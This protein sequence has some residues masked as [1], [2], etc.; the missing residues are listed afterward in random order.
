MRNQVNRWITAIKENR[1]FEN[2]APLIGTIF[3]SD[4]EQ[5]RSRRLIPREAASQQYLN[6]LIEITIKGHD[7]ISRTCSWI[8]N[9]K[10]IFGKCDIPISW[11]WRLVHYNRLFKNRSP[12]IG[13]ILESNIERGGAC[14]VPS[15]IRLKSLFN[16]LII[17]SVKSKYSRSIAS[18]GICCAEEKLTRHYIT[19]SRIG[20]SRLNTQSL[21]EQR[22]PLIRFVLY[23]NIEKSKPVSQSPTNIIFI[24]RFNSV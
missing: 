8:K 20:G 2:W 1:P 17:I 24:G 9:S 13:L 23:T 15:I 21:F 11:S 16:C 6:S 3:N 10:E 5:S 7:Y 22:P 19:H 18:T 12:H 4:I 14:D